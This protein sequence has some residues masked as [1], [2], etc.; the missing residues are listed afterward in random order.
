M[1][2]PTDLRIGNYL[3]GQELRIPRLQIHS[4]GISEITAYGIHL[5]S[6]GIDVGLKPIF[7]THFWFKE[8]GFERVKKPAT[9]GGFEYLYSKPFK[10]NGLPFKFEVW[11]DENGSFF[12]MFQLTKYELDKKKYVHQLQNMYHAFT[13]QELRRSDF[14]NK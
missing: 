14:I 10:H 4:N 2:K 9:N 3:K 7:L 13:E 6:E 12:S 1:F 8:F 5:M 11:S